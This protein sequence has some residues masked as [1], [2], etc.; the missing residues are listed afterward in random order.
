MGVA[1]AGAHELN[2]G[3]PT[4][5]R[6]PWPLPHSFPLAHQAPANRRAWLLLWLT[7]TLIALADAGL[8]L[9]GA[10]VTVMVEGRS[11]SLPAGLTVEQAL[12]RLECRP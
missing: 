4:P 2:P 10:S 7:A 12:G 5:R 11:R 1:A 8:L 6:D 9:R 3:P